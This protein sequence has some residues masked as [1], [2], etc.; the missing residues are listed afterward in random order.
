MTRLKDDLSVDMRQ[1]PAKST[2]NDEEV[3]TDG[4]ECSKAY[5]MLISYAN[6]DE[7]LDAVAR[8]LEEECVGN[9]DGGCWVKNTTVYHALDKIGV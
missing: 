5:K 3:P 2:A 7:R 1:I 9:K 6:T 8:V 4:V